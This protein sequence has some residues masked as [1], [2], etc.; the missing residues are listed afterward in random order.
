MKGSKFLSVL[1]S[2]LTAVFLLTGGIAVPILW[3]GFYYWQ[4]DALQLPYRSGFSAEVVKG[5]FDQVMDYLV[6]GA[7][8]GTGQL[9][10]SEEGMA[11]FA[12]C[13]ALFRLD[14]IVL[15]VCAAAL[16]VIAVLALKGKVRLHRFLDRGPCFWGTIG[17]AAVLAVVLVWALTDFD[18]LFT[19]FHTAFFPGKTNWVFDWR[20]DQIILILPEDF[21]ARAAALVGV[22]ALGGGAVL[23]GIESFVHRGREPDTVYQELTEM[24]KDPKRL[25]KK[26]RREQ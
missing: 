11:H 17:L 14:F 22:V 12:D 23:S 7:E 10:W 13:K 8:F 18:G 20:S 4:M 9:K 16:V 25:Q 1:T 5:A 6:K 26:G 19:A 2:L 15:G 24:R 21:W 3:R